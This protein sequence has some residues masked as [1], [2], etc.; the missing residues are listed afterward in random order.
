MLLEYSFLKVQPLSPVEAAGAKERRPYLS[1]LSYLSYYLARFSPDIYKGRP[2]GVNEVG[3]W[4]IL[5]AWLGLS[6]LCGAKHGFAL[7]SRKPR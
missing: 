7:P 3:I 5:W 1:Y 2:L 4:P 6:D